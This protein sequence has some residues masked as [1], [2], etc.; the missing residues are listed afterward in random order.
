MSNTLT[1]T[2][3]LNATPAQLQ[4]A[5]APARDKRG[6][7]E[8]ATRVAIS[9]RLHVVATTYK[10]KSR[11]LVTSVT[12]QTA[13]GFG[14][15]GLTIS[16]VRRSLLANFNF[17]ESGKRATA[18]AITDNQAHTLQ[19]LQAWAASLEEKARANGQELGEYLAQL[20]KENGETD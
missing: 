17:S 10:S 6:E 15:W 14:M 20:F 5:A 4:T 13:R 9:G 2:E 18:K 7:L 12:A 1:I 11:G 3:L 19:R 8:S 16:F